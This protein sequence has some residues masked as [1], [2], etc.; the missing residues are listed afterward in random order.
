M[1]RIILIFSYAISTISCNENK[2]RNV[3]S[4]NYRDYETLQIITR[5]QKITISKFSDSAEYENTKYDSK[6]N[7]NPQQY[8]VG[9]IEKRKIYFSEAEKDS[10]SKYIFQSIT[11]PKF[12]DISA[13]DYV[14][15]V[16]LN[17]EKHNMKLINKYF[18]VGDWSEVSENTKK[19]YTLLKSKMEISRQ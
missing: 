6:V 13:T 12:T 14:G 18:S 10:L 9:K 17:F 11:N 2:S 19:I 3:E 15:N 1:K 8:N 7:K 16:E 5:N 4:E